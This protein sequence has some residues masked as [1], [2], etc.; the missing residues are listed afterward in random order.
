M[1]DSVSTTINNE[2][3]LSRRL[4]HRG[5]PLMTEI[6]PHPF[7]RRTCQLHHL[8]WYRARAFPHRR[9]QRR[10]RLRSLRPPM[11]LPLTLR[12]MCLRQDLRYLRIVRYT[13]QH[14]CSI[15]KNRTPSF[16]IVRRPALVLNRC[17]NCQRIA[18]ERP[19]LQH[20]LARRSVIPLCKVDQASIHPMDH[21]L[22]LLGPH[23]SS[24]PSRKPSGVRLEVHHPNTAL[25]P[26]LMT[27]RPYR[28]KTDCQLGRP[29]R[30]T[31]PVDLAPIGRH[32]EAWVLRLPSYMSH[33]RKLDHR[34][35]RDR[36]QKQ[37]RVSIQP[38]AIRT[39]TYR[40]HLLPNV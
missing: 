6:H 40:H 39:I 18:S 35:H 30:A 28:R 27:V 11:Q 31:E 13:I 7:R 25:E 33:P 10:Y 15:L 1:K 16:R 24:R 34:R 5:Q 23:G 17:Q 20:D 22:P 21:P 37:S 32:Q 36:S 2:A 9:P 29:R 4:H 12:D 3:Y 26:T 14:Q 8:Q 19:R 38:E